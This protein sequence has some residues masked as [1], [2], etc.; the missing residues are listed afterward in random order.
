MLTLCTASEFA[1]TGVSIRIC[2]LFSMTVAL[3]LAAI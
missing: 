1:R 2:L 3:V